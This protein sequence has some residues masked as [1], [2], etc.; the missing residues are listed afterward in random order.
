MIKAGV[1]VIPG[2]KEAVYDV[3]EGAKIAKKIGAEF[4]DSTERSRDRFW[5]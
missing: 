1:P 2:S 4:P 5:R 3:K